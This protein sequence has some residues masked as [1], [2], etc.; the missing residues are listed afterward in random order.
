[1]L[2]ESLLVSL[3]TLPATL[4]CFGQAVMTEPGCLVMCVEGRGA[5]G[6]MQLLCCTLHTACMFLGGPRAVACCIR[7]DLT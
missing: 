6:K 4:P 3:A 7:I 2:L 1:M 5:I